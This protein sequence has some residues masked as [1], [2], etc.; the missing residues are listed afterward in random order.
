MRTD[1]VAFII[2]VAKYYKKIHTLLCVVVFSS[3]VEFI[4]IGHTMIDIYADISVYSSVRF[5]YTVIPNT[6]KLHVECKRMKSCYYP[7]LRRSLFLHS[8]DSSQA[9]IATSSPPMWNIRNG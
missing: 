9:P 1:T 6:C 4:I 2:T 3:S 5:T 7:I 8:N